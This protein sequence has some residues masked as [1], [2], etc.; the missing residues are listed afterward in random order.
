MRLISRFRQKV[1]RIS[2]VEVTFL[3]A[4]F[5]VL[6][7]LELL[8]RSSPSDLADLLALSVIGL[9]AVLMALIHQKHPLRTAALLQDVC[10][11]LKCLWPLHNIELGVDLRKSPPLPRGVPRSWSVLLAGL[12]T[13]L[14]LLAVAAPYF[15]HAARDFLVERFY[16]GYV[17]L[18]GI[19]WGSMAAAIIATAIL[20][21]AAIHDWFIETYRGEGLRPVRREMQLTC[22][23]FLLLMF[24]AMV[25]PRWVPLLGFSIL[26]VVHGSILLLANGG[27]II[28]WKDRRGGAVKSF[29]GRIL[30][31]GQGAIPLLL[32]VN[33]ALLSRGD[34]FR[35]LAG[36]ALDE[37]LPLTTAL[38]EVLIWTSLAGLSA[39]TLAVLR[40]AVLG[41]LYNPERPPLPTACVEGPVARETFQ[42]LAEWLR[43]YGWRL[44][45]GKLSPRKT[46]VSIRVDES[47]D[48]SPR[49]A[50]SG[51]PL[52][53]HAATRPGREIMER[54]RRREEIQN[55]RALKRGLEMLFK[56]AARLS[57]PRG[58]GYWVGPQHW[59]ILGLGRDTHGTEE[60]DRETTC[61]NNI[62]GPPFHRVLPARSRYHFLQI[63]TALEVDLIFVEDGVSFRRFARVLSMMFE[64]YDVFGGRQ[65]AEEKHFTGLP[66]VRVLLHDFTLDGSTA[67]GVERY[68][69][70]DYEE[71]GRARILHVFRDRGE[72]EEESFTPSDFEGV[73]VLSGA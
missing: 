28:L 50:E 62:I 67:H 63:T 55:R 52:V 39:L 73:P 68:P 41:I 1:R 33:L 70:P 8:G 65:R 69:E 46:G 12:T 6:T 60:G 38:G 10:G 72:A 56:R 26:F 36:A 53:L 71:L 22:G 21:W 66:G 42:R 54:L 61:L 48:A 16:L 51:W 25:L 34:S 7:A 13:A 18:L 5:A 35:P 32:L 20:P 47:A 9:L 30:L 24:G 44:Q 29:D 64:V 37:S 27:L 57:N 40:Y 58:S 14:L 3:G 4:S 49:T 45:R 31:W 43:E 15:P 59:F 23:V 2:P 17:L 19:L 11:R